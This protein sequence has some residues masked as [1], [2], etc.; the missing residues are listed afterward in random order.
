MKKILSILLFFCILFS[1]CGC[2]E[3]IK[4]DE[5]FVKNLGKSLEARWKITDNSKQETNAETRDVLSKAIAAEE[6]K[7]GLFEDYTFENKNIEEYAKLYFDSLALQKDGYQYYGLDDTKYKEIFGGGLAGRYKAVYLINN[8]IP[9]SVSNSNRDNLESFFQNGK[10][11]FDED[12]KL[13][14]VEKMLQ[15]G[16]TAEFDGSEYQMIFDNQ[17]G[18]DF[19]SIN[20]NIN[21]YDKDGV[22]TNNSTCYLNDWKNGTKLKQSLWTYG[23]PFKTAK[24]SASYY[25]DY[26]GSYE[27]GKTIEY[28]LNLKNDYSINI[29]LKTELPVELSYGFSGRIY[30][31]CRVDTFDYYESAWYNGVASVDFVFSG[32]KTYDR[33]GENNND[34]CQFSW[35]LYDA[36]GFVIDSG[37]VYTNEIT[38]GQTFKDVKS[39]VYDIKPGNYTIELIDY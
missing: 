17:T 2:G 34:N 16:I 37:T 4:N 14:A 15:D 18:Y 8:E 31:K 3:K 26:A 6:E 7:L 11:I 38:V 36:E 39:Y 5:T 12:S 20:F 9:I 35:K 13:A 21:Y 24:I 33:S 30:T 29:E 10:K 28:D 25:R 32:E 1:L 27:E 19:D 23:S 22:I